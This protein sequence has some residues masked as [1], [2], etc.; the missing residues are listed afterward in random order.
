MI[1]GWAVT[2]GPYCIGVL[3]DD[4]GLIGIFVDRLME[5]CLSGLGEMM[6]T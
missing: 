2:V 5:R 6:S 3:Y 4:H 1:D